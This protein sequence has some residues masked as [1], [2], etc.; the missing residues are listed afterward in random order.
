MLFWNVASTIFS[1]INF[2][3]PFISKILILKDLIILIIGIKLYFVWKRH[4]LAFSISCISRSIAS[5]VWFLTWIK[6]INSCNSFCLFFL[7]LRYNLAKFIRFLRVF[8]NVF[9]SLRSYFNL[10]QVY[11]DFYH[12]STS[13]YLNLNI[14]DY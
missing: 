13:V 4:R 12:F 6:L 9:I 14:Y 2:L 7:L 10:I 11:L 8:V 1:L 3:K 5:L